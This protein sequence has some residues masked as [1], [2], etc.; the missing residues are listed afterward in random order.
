MSFIFRQPL[1]VTEP[2]CQHIECRWDFFIERIHLYIQTPYLI[3]GEEQINNT[4]R[5]YM[6]DMKYFV[7]YVPRHIVQ[8]MAEFYQQKQSG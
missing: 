5:V 1:A 4:V 3:A 2:F 6:P 8:E 7:D